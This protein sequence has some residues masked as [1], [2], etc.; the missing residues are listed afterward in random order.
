M[1]VLT[2]RTISG[3]QGGSQDN[4]RTAGINGR[5]LNMPKD[6]M[7]PVKVVY[8]IATAPISAV[9]DGYLKLKTVLLGPGPSR[10]VKRSGSR[11]RGAKDAGLKEK[12]SA[13]KLAR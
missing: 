4:E 3:G 2:T 8:S 7:W 11:S 6:M 5:P 13:S 10:G 9:E 1:P 12:R